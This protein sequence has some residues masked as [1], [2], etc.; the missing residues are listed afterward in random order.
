MRIR[1]LTFLFFF[2]LYFTGLSKPGILDYII[3]IE[4]KSTPV[5][6]ILN[7]IEQIGRVQ[8][9][10][11]PELIDE[12]RLVSLNIKNKSIR[13]G[14]SFIFDGS[15]RIKEVG[16]HIVL[17]K[18]E[19]KSDIK[20]REKQDEQ[21]VFSGKITDELT[22]LPIYRASVYDVDSRFAV[23]TDKRG[24]YTLSI[25]IAERI[26]SLY[27]SRKGYKREVIVVDAKNKSALSNDIVLSP[28]VVTIEKIKGN[29]VTEIP[30]GFEDKALSGVL[31]SYETY[32]HG[33]NLPEI[34]ETRLAQISLVPSVSIGSNL[35]TNGLII[36]NFSLNV[37]SGYSKGVNGLEIGGIANVVNGDVRWCQIGGITNLVAGDVTG[38]QVAGISNLVEGNVIGVQV[39]GIRSGIDGEMKGVQVSGINSIVRSNAVGVQVSGIHSMVTN[40]MEGIQISG[41]RSV[42]NGDMK[43]LQISGISSSVIGSYHGV[44]ISGIKN[45]IK[46]G[47]YGMQISGIY[48]EVVDTLFGG[49]I[50]GIGNRALKGNTYAQISG[51][52][53]LSRVNEGVQLSSIYNQT[54]DNKGIQTGLINISKKS[55]GVALGLINYVEDGYHKVEVSTNEIFH[56]NVVVKSGSQRLYNSYS[57]G[58]RFGKAP[59]CVAGLGLGSYFNLTK[60]SM[61]SVDFSA[62]ASF[63]STDYNS[64]LNK[65][66]LTF[67]YKPA[68][69]ITIFAGPSINSS[70]LLNG[71]DGIEFPNQPFYEKELSNGSL[72]LW[73]GGQFG[74][75]L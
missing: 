29:E 34:N 59:V 20:A 75:R 25:P 46:E 7:K 41:I 74:I 19:N 27:F 71:G 66:S 18:N 28:I 64:M 12:N 6:L 62:H 15:I 55:S 47:A 33:E 65:L 42:A 51:I 38:V 21:Y 40:D 58:F 35:S 49:Q 24:N 45:V 30:N 72:E 5:K 52:F 11:N 43:G 54:N 53:N 56:A 10:Y 68:K 17:L 39:S 70:V 22:G 16:E 69:W 9:S 61:L 26:R 67:D 13:Y 44:Q 32:Q 37:L 1:L 48:N 50:S 2:M 3:S 63:N 36:N 14:L 8:F 57:F 31:V 60:K 73:I 23:L 4:L